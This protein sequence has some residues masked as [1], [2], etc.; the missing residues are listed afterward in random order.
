MISP[1]WIKNELDKIVAG[2][3]EAKK[4]LSVLGYNHFLRFQDRILAAERLKI[5]ASLPAASPPRLTGLITGPTGTGKTFLIEALAKILTFPVLKIDATQISRQGFSGM[6][7]SEYIITLQDKYKGTVQEDFL[8]T[9]IIFIDEIDK[10]GGK[11]TTTTSDNHNREIQ[12]GILAFIDGT[13]SMSRDANDRKM[14][15]V[16]TTKMLFLFG[17]AF[18]PTYKQRHADKQGLGFH[19]K[20]TGDAEVFNSALTRDEIEGAGVMRELLGRIHAIT[21]TTRLDKDQIIDV[22]FNVR[23]NLVSQFKA[24]FDMSEIPTDDFEKE[25]VDNV[26]DKIAANNNNYGMRYAKTILFDHFKEKIFNLGCDMQKEIE[27]VTGEACE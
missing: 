23:E 22:L 19:G 17:G 27:K 5:G 11:V 15:V 25:I 14:H 12:S 6:S 8:D 4:T 21:H 26:V 13:A 7:F 20:T 10:L 16:D 18:E 1:A 9:A 3:D 2:Q 24:I